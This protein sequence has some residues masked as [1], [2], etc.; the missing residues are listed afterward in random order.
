ME[1]KKVKR[2]STY[3]FHES[4]GLVVKREAKGIFARCGHRQSIRAAQI[5]DADTLETNYTRRVRRDGLQQETRGAAYFAR[6][7]AASG[8]I[9]AIVGEHY[10]QTEKGQTRW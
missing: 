2:E 9:P 7:Q 10:A 5:R 3:L 6:H 8:E 1:D 4:W